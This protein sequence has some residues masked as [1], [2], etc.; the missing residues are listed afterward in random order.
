MSVSEKRKRIFYLFEYLYYNSDEEHPLST[1]DIMDFF[2]NKG[3]AVDRKTLKTDLDLLMDTDSIFSI[4]MIK[5][6]PNK[7]YWKDRLFED[8]ELTLLM[9]AVSSA[10][11]IPE[12]KTDELIEKIMKLTD[13]YTKERIK[14]HAMAPNKAKAMNLDVYDIVGKISKA[15]ELNKKIQFRYA[16]YNPEMKRMDYRRNN[17]N[18]YKYYFVSPY[19]MVWNDDY[20]YL[21][22][23]SD[24]KEKVC[25][26]RI[27]KMEIPVI[28]MEDAVKKPKS[29]KMDEYAMKNFSMYAGDENLV[30]LLVDNSVM[31]YVFDRFGRNI[32][33]EY[34][35]DKSSL[36]T[37]KVALSPPFYSWVFQFGGKIKILSPEI[38]K[39]GFRSLLLQALK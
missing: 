13:V 21:V 29:L 27:D 36:A 23:W 3:I 6:S 16:E 14:K 8:V 11:F 20:Y 24:S 17:Y 35:N 30:T 39:K 9:N 18:L 32:M 25:H 37:V 12:D 38:A 4:E 1:K 34:K 26:Y 28:T 19:F 15:I 31:N 33:T 22:G 7:Y 10:R 5:S 2:K